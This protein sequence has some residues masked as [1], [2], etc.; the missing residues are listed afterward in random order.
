MDEAKNHCKEGLGVFE[1][2]S[3]NAKDPHIV[4]ACAGDTPTLEVIAASKIL[5]E[6]APHINTRVVNVIDLMRL[7]SNEKHPHGLTNSEF[8]KYFTKDKHVIFAFHGYPNLIHE[9]IYNRD[10][11]NFHVHGYLEEGTITTPFDMR[12]QN[13]IDR[14]NLVLDALKYVEETDEVRLTR[15]LMKKKLKEHKEYIVEE[16]IDLEEIRNFNLR[17]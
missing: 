16:G 2:A 11:H 17:G 9:L 3:N 12:V 1:W 10:N 5:K 13:K 14:F 7:Q 8:N 6:Y 4:L 15:N